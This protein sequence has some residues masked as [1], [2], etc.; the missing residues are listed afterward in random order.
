MEGHKIAQLIAERVKFLRQRE[1]GPW[2]KAPVVQVNLD[3]QSG[4]TTAGLDL[5]ELDPDA[6]MLVQNQYLKEQLRWH[7]CYDRV[8]TYMEVV[9]FFRGQRGPDMVIMDD[10][11]KA[12]IPNEVLLSVAHLSRNPDFVEVRLG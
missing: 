4:H 9:E 11:S 8:Y 3:R 12:H 1:R 2:D 7:P 10:F 5:L 6:V